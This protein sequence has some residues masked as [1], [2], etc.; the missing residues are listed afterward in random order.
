MS[1]INIIST[2]GP[3]LSAEAVTVRDLVTYAYDLKGY[4]LSFAPPLPTVAES[5]YDV[6]AKAQG[7][8]VLTKAEFKQM[9]QTLLADRFNLKVHRE[10]KEFPVYA[11]VVGKNGPKF[12]E[13]AP[14]A[15]FVSNHGVNGRNQNMT[16]SKVTMQ[17]VAQEIQGYFGI[18]RPILDQTGLTGTYD[19]RIEATPEFRIN[20]NP[21]DSRALS[22]FVAVQQQLGLRLEPQ[23]QPLEILVVDHVE[24][25]SGN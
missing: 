1:R 8:G 4:Q 15:T 12:K 9:L 23:K 2:S 17:D 20:G 11:L 14:D 5:Y 18:A 21:D 10:M 22:V 19:I 13:S 25:P 3:M 16:L 24:R 7:E 6:V